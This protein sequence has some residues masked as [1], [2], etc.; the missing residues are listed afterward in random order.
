MGQ[1][2]FFLTWHQDSTRSLTNGELLQGLNYLCNKGLTFGGKNCSGVPNTLVTLTHPYP[3]V[4][5]RFDAFLFW[6]LTRGQ[7]PEADPSPEVT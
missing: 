4:T 5:F 2:S 1:S 6:H 7:E 3:L